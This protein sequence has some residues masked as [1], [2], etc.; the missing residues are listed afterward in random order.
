[1]LDK[2][3][4]FFR[5][6]WTVAWAYLKIAAGFVIVAAPVIGD[7]LNDPNIG[8]HLPS[9]WVGWALLA[10]GVITYGARVLPHLGDA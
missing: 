3:K 6:S 5:H 4:A 9:Q 2:I 1:M 7:A 8:P 10:I